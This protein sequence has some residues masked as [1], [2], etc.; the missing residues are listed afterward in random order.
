MAWS[1]PHDVSHSSSLWLCLSQ[2]QSCLSLMWS[3]YSLHLSPSLDCIGMFFVST[4]M[5]V[6]SQSALWYCSCSVGWRAFNL[7]IFVAHP[8]SDL[9]WFHG[10]VYIVEAMWNGLTHNFNE[11]LTWHCNRL[12]NI[13]TQINE[14]DIQRY[15]GSNIIGHIMLCLMMSSFSPD[16]A[17]F[18]PFQSVCIAAEVAQ[19]T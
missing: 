4:V 9:F 3:R 1:R 11:S 7:Q 15:N 6:A 10:S 5:F 16:V 13:H 19:L 12:S 8:T 17:T 18:G 2:L 14:E